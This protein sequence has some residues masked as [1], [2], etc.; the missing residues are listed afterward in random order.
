MFKVALTKEACQV[1]YHNN[2][3]LVPYKP[4][5]NK[6]ILLL[7]SLHSEVNKVENKPEIVLHYNKIIEAS[8]TFD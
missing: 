4:E 6:I 3:T 1:A 5:N 7:S 8:D 2:K